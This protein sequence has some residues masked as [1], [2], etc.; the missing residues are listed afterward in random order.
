MNK[1]F[2]I[3]VLAIFIF[4]TSFLLPTDASAQGRHRGHDKHGRFEERYTKREVEEIIRRVEEGSDRFRKDLDRDLDRSR[5]DGSKK[6]DRINENIK[7]FERA[8]DELRKDFD[9]RDSWWE[10][11]SN[12]QVALDA[13]RPVAT[14]MRNNPFSENVRA[15]WRN[16]R[17]DLNRLAATYNLPQ[18]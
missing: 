6:E 15:Q 11:R 12:V 9:R 2:F 14:R 18:V 4:S 10:S 17:N 7:K 16:L 13:A 1:K 3:L 5:L 8:L